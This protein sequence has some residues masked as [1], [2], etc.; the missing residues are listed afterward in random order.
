[1]KKTILCECGKDIN[2]YNRKHHY[3]SKQ[4]Q[5]CVEEGIKIDEL[6]KRKE[7]MMLKYSREYYKKNA[8]RI[9]KSRKEYYENN[10]EK[11]IQ[12]SKNYRLKNQNKF[13]WLLENFGK[14]LPEEL[15][16]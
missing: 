14:E 4:H 11:V 5:V 9:S 8:D 3:K 1:M 15:K 12:R 16:T 13:K 6:Q 7:E 10:K 2:Y